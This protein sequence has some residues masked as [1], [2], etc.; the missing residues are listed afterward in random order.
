MEVEF[1]RILQNLTDVTLFCKRDKKSGAGGQPKGPQNT[2]VSTC[3]N[4]YK[5]HL[6]TADMS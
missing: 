3:V 2:E 1:D 4:N 6:V 5:V